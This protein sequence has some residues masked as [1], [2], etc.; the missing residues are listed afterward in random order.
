[1][2][3]IKVNICHADHV[4]NLQNILSLRCNDFVNASGLYDCDCGCMELFY[5]F[6]ALGRYDYGGFI[7]ICETVSFKK[8]Y[9]LL[10]FIGLYPKLSLAA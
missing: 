8:W 3:S 6:T 5:Q 7:R 1:M 10:R 9:F 4:Y 2:D